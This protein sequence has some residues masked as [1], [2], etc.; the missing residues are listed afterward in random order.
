MNL[1]EGKELT[2]YTDPVKATKGKKAEPPRRITLGVRLIFDDGRRIEVGGETYRGRGTMIFYHYRYKTYKIH[3]PKR[4][5]FY[6][7]GSVIMDKD[8][9]V[10]EDAEMASKQTKGLKRDEFLAQYKSWGEG[11]VRMIDNIT[12]EA[13]MSRM[14][15]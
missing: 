9:P 11:I 2:V 8:G 3:P 15:A 10:W 14:A 4:P 13:A 12:A 7:S 6:K 5:T 1:I